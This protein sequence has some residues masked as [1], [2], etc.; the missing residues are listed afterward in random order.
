MNEFNP[1][2]WLLN[3]DGN[4]TL[5]FIVLA[6]FILMWIVIVIF[7]RFGLREE[8]QHHQALAAWKEVAHT[9]GFE[10]RDLG[11]QDMSIEGRAHGFDV[12]LETREDPT[13]NKLS[14]MGSLSTHLCVSGIPKESAR[15]LHIVTGQASLQERASSEKND[16]LE[17]VYE[18]GDE[19]SKEPSQITDPELRAILLKLAAQYRSVTV[20][21]GEVLVERDSLAVA[22]SEVTDMIDGAL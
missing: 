17:D 12:R 19:L 15:D 3:G 5:G 13:G 21:H 6:L 1:P 10:F 2:F 7:A 18:R 4:S 8:S 22:L 11:V 14:D 20:K 9:V 16:R